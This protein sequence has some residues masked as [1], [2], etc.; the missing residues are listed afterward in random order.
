MAHGLSPQLEYF[1]TDDKLIISDIYIKTSRKEPVFNID[2]I[3]WKANRWGSIFFNLGLDKISF[4]EIFIIDEKEE[5]KLS[6][7]HI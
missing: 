6:L 5:K 3:D 2:Y 4:E 7:I 1:L